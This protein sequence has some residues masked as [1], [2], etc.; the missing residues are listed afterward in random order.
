[1]LIDRGHVNDFFELMNSSSIEYVLIKNINGELPAHLEDGKDIDILVQEK[2]KDEFSALMERNEF[3]KQVPPMGRE[4]GWNFAYQLPEYQFWKK[5]GIQEN[6]YIDAS[7]KLCCKSLTPKTWIPLD[8]CINEDI[9]E[10]RIYDQEN[11]WWIMDSRTIFIYMIVRSIFDK[12]NFKSDYIFDIE[13]NIQY[14][15][16]EEV[17][18]KLESVFF[19]YT[20]CLIQMLKDRRYEEI[21]SDYIQFVEY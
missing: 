6:L 13:K 17:V 8:N 5:K 12:R 16:D 20:N 10:R 4:K 19:K 18:R 1:M 7:F 3:Q 15:D 9:W 2:Y 21:F 14:L 11:K